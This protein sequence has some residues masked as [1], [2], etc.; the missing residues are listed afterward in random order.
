MTSAHGKWQFPID[1]SIGLEHNKESAIY[2]HCICFLHHSVSKRDLIFIKEAN[3]R[4]C[5]QLLSCVILF[6]TPWTVAFQ[7]PLSMGFSSQEFW[8][9]LRF[10]PPGNLPDS[11]IKPC[12]FCIGRR[13]LYHWATWETQRSKYLAYLPPLLYLLQA[14]QRHC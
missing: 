5:V 3:A 13:I 10:P 11:G 9:V 1:S 14:Q 8:S 2:F 12:I 6:S 7:T 4:M